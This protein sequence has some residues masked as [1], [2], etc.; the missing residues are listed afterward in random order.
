MTADAETWGLPLQAEIGPDRFP[1]V[2]GTALSPRNAATEV[3]A[4]YLRRLVWYTPTALD[5]SGVDGEPKSWK[6]NQVLTTW[7][8]S[9]TVLAYPAASVDEDAVPYEEHSLVPTVLEETLGCYGRGTVLW[10]TAEIALDFQVDFWTNAEPDREAIEAGLPR[11]F[12]LTE[13]RYGV[14]LSGHPRYFD[15]AVRATLVAHDRLDTSE[16]AYARERRLRATIRIE[17]DVVHLRHAAELTPRHRLEVE[18]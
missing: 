18:E 5:S 13:G 9:G 3:L 8:A 1:V 10:K 15:R 7:P 6:L 2:G 14:M 4:A 17:I 11:A 12:A 16:D